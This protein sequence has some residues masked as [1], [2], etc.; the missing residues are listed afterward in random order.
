MILIVNNQNR[1]SERIA[2]RAMFEA[3]KQVFID[4]L[5]WDLPVLAGRFE[6][7]QF[8][9]ARATYLIV[10][11]SERRHLASARLL[12][13]DEPGILISLFPDLCDE[14]PPGGPNVL[15]IT[16]FCLSRE[17][18]AADRRTA[19]NMLVT[20]IAQFGIANGVSSYTG[21]ADVA[22]LQQILAFGWSCRTLGLSRTHSGKALGALRIDIEPDTLDKLATAGVLCE[23]RVAAAL[24]AA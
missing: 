7:D 20:A 22:W 21:V 11:D 14:P 24:H 5:G 19:R 16:R 4:L 8:D 17:L 1:M 6:V 3:R 10:T 12:P 18:S 13:T 2:L 9:N 15:E 23:P